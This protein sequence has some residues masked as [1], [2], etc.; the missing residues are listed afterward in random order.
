MRREFVTLL[1]SSGMTAPMFVRYGRAMKD[2]GPGPFVR[3]LS[4]IA[5]AL[6]DDREMTCRP[7]LS[8]DS[9]I[10][11]KRIPSGPRSKQIL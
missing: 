1:G 5:Y 3:Y 2:F 6:R 9:I 7:V 10:E 4:N 8:R 11:K